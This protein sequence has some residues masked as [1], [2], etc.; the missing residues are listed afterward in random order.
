[1][2]PPQWQTP[3]SQGATRRITSPMWR[4]YA[5]RAPRRVTS[6]RFAPSA[7]AASA[8]RRAMTHGSAPFAQIALAKDITHGTAPSAYATSA[9]LEVMTHGSA[10]F[11]QIALV[12]DINH[13]TAPSAYAT[14]ATLEVMIN[15][16]APT[17]FA[18]FARAKDTTL[19]NATISQ[20][21]SRTMRR[22]SLILYAQK[23]IWYQSHV[24]MR[25]T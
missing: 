23:T 10:L 8:T 1:M 16:N 11:A 18:A 19:G 15:G 12:K 21:R 25:A 17:S 4:S 9:T 7:Y 14:S 5:P 24:S 3:R 13:G 20:R 2:P 22:A 6:L